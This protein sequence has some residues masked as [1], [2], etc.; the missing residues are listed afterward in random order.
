MR[1]D[2]DREKNTGIL[3]YYTFSSVFY[4]QDIEENN[5]GD[6]LLTLTPVIREECYGKKPS[7]KKVTYQIL[8][9]KIVNNL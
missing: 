5:Y 4:P 2:G 1:S 6:L 8:I 3:S 7:N 9:T